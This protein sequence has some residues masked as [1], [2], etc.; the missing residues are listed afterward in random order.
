[1]GTDLIRL[2][3]RFC[4]GSEWDVWGTVHSGAVADVEGPLVRLPDGS[5][6]EL[7]SEDM[8]PVRCPNCLQDGTFIPDDE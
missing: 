6:F 2:R 1:M 8:T 5:I 4:E 7:D 3:C